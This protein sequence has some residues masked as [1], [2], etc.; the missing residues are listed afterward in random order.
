MPNAA[1]CVVPVRA[2]E[3]WLLIDEDA[4]RSAAGNPK[5]R[6]PLDMPPLGTLESLPQPKARLNGLLR[7]ASGL[8]PRRRFH[9]PP[10]IHRL[11]DLIKDFSPLRHLPAF[12]ELEADVLGIL[13]ERAWL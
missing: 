6:H 8:P 2:M 13:A 9:P 11:A 4:L 5:G 3:A 7:A 1:V 10:R 12:R